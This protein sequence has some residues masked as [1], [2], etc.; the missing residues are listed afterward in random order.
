MQIHLDPAADTCRIYTCGDLVRGEVQVERQ[1]KARKVEIR[2]KGRSRIFIPADPDTGAEL[3]TIDLFSFHSELFNFAGEEIGAFTEDDRTHVSFPFE[4]R[5]PWVVQLAAPPRKGVPFARSDDFE[6]LRGHPL[7]PSLTHTIEYHLD[8]TLTTASLAHPKRAVRTALAFS[9]PCPPPTRQPPPISKTTSLCRRHHRLDP[10]PAAQHAGL[11]SRVKQLLAGAAPPVTFALTTTA[12]AVLRAG[13]PLAPA[14]TVALTHL[15]RAAAVPAPPSV[16]LRA[17]SVAL[18]ARTLTRL[19]GV[20]RERRGEAV[21]EAWRVARR[22]DGVGEAPVL[23][24]DCGV[25]EL[26]KVGAGGSC[27]VVPPSVVPDFR[28]YGVARAYELEVVLSVQC[29]GKVFEVEGARHRVEVLPMVEGEREG[30]MV[31]E[32]VPPPYQP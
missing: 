19:P 2:F 22:C 25:L 23:L 20:G 12:P 29:V 16:T 28:T 5:F 4:F 9:P 24:E 8:A 21:E 15:D 1:E 11:R 13:R 30:L 6:H 31:G 3:T 18:R 14:V 26:G 17:F 7:P 10:R 32:E 27:L